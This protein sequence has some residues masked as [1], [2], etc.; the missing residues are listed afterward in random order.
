MS[1]IRL[2]L[3]A[4]VPFIK[5]ELKLSRTEVGFL[6]SVLNLG[7]IA[8]GIPAGKAA[9]RFGE[10][11][12]IGFAAIAAGLIV[13]GVNWVESY[14]SLVPALILTGIAAGSSTPAGSKAVAG[15]F[16][17]DERGTA[18][19]VRQMA[20][21][22]GGAIAALSLPPLAIGFGWRIAFAAAGAAAVGSGLI[23]GYFY[24]E[25]AGTPV[26]S[27][28]RAV[29]VADLALRKEILAVLIFAF[30][31][32]GGQW[33]YLT[34]LQLYLVEVVRLPLTMAAALLAS[35][36]IFGAAGRIIWGV[37]SDKLFHGRRKP[38]LVIVGILAA[39]MSF[40]ISLFT[41]ETPLWLIVLSFALLGLSLLG[42]QGL[43]FALIS[44]LVESRAAGVA[45]GLNQSVALSGIMLLP[46]L[47]GFFVDM[48]ESYRGAWI[49]LSGLIL[50]TLS[51]FGWI[52][53]K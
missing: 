40:A 22:L 26:P 10:K 20:V 51:F 14:G 13:M 28:K 2:G 24:E 17:A 32:G 4:L 42:W 5:A 48:T 33:C 46:P 45:I 27:K 1:A 37:S 19:G 31:L 23:A 11:P 21:P 43:S 52:R 6:S 39:L 18:M 49:L 30:V 16:S 38:A 9:D 12:L 50:F 44:E 34:Y 3:P 7:S 35:G 8:A 15:W 29:G 41:P 47:F 53:E 36:Q 25:P